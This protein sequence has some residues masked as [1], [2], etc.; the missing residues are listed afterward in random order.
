MPTHFRLAQHPPLPWQ[1]ARASADA[2]SVQPHVNAADTKEVFVSAHRGAFAQ[3]PRPERA[4]SP[5]PSYGVPTQGGEL[6]P[7]SFVIEQL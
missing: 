3:P 5:P 4:M 6:M 1:A 7:W 2:W